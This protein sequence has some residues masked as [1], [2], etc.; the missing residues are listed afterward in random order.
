MALVE[1]R[2]AKVPDDLDAA[3]LLIDVLVSTE[4]LGEAMRRAQAQVDANPSRPQ[5]WYLLGRATQDPAAAEEAYQHALRVDSNHAR[6]W[7]GLGAVRRG[8]GAGP[9]AENA[10]RR[11]LALDPSLGE[12]WV[13]VWTMELARD[14]DAAAQATMRAAIKVLPTLPEAWLSLSVLAPQEAESLLTRAAKAIPDDVRIPHALARNRVGRGDFKAALAAYDQALAL[15]PQMDDLTVERGLCAEVV[16]K[17]LKPEDATHLLEIRLMASQDPEEALPV[18]DKVVAANAQSGWARLI[19]G[20]LLHSLQQL[21]LAE[22]DL[23]AALDR[24]PDSPSAMSGLGVLLLSTH[25]ASDARPLL[26]KAAKGRPW[27]DSLA[28]AAAMA[29]AEAGDREAAIKSLE[30]ALVT[31][32]AS[33]G[34]PLGLAQVKLA[35]GDS[36]GAYLVLRDAVRRTPDPQLALAMGGAALQ[37]GKGEEAATI[38][39]ELFVRTGYSGFSEAARRIRAIGAPSP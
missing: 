8:T 15:Q 32:P 10:Y 1:Q 11:A 27:D 2:L 28:V 7:M 5:G 37:A 20:N 29:A 35:Q 6:S 19:R 25:R 24:M 31:F 36:M 12:A 22:K 3:E 4:Q 38:L 26:E 23:R 16:R 14:D 13:G 34:P 21:S 18:V 17:A 33:T 9:E 39:D 30:A